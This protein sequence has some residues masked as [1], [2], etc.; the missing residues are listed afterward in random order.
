MKK[1]K[2]KVMN[3]NES[4]FESYHILKRHYLKNFLDCEENCRE[5]SEFKR[6]QFK[7]LLML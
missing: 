7:N 6:K 1:T 2:K 5:S 4:K 3:S